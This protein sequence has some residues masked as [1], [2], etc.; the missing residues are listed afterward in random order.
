MESIK[1]NPVPIK[2]GELKSAVEYLSDSDEHQR[3][4][5][6]LCS[7]NAESLPIGMTVYIEKTTVERIRQAV[8]VAKKKAAP[9]SSPAKPQEPKS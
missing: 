5:K 6:A 9:M 3:I 8:E 4:D 7:R 2:V 1:S